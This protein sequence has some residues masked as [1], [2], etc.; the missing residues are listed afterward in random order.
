MTILLVI[1]ILVLLIVAHEFGHFIVAKLFRVRVEE[2]GIGY[3]PRAFTFGVWGGTEYTI[4][5]L[6]FGGFVRLF[7]ED[8]LENTRERG[9]FAH[10]SLFAQAAILVAGV[11]MNALMAWVLFAGALSSGLPHVVSDASEGGE[12]AR[13]IVASVIPGSPAEQAGIAPGDVII[14][15]TDE[16]GQ[17]TPLSPA[18]VSAFV[19]ERGGKPVSIA[20]ERSGEMHT[21]TVLPAHAVV[22]GDEGRPAVGLGL[23]LVSDEKLGFSDALW[24]AVPRTLDAFRA[25]GS[26]LWHL[27]AGFF[28]G[29]GS[30][31][32]VVG[33]VG[34]FGVVGSAAEHGFAHVLALAAFISVNLSIVNLL[35]VPA[36]DGGR[37]VMVAYEAVTRRPPPRSIFRAL[38]LAGIAAIALL[39]LA[40]TYH[41][42]AR[43]LA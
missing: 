24:E 1:A 9:A 40:V 11:A 30:L 21:E 19:G 4:N 34:L 20:Y 17:N 37:L 38:N 7:G 8:E 16:S 2:F 14:R 12:H 13:L 10:A 28:R 18:E 39:M 31:N 41:D 27:L 3:P 5:W 25:V 23:V 6:P 29:E 15:V 43:L 26:G 36:L 32:D 33:P 22:R 42:I 35:P